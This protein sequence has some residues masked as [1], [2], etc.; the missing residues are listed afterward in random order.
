MY[1]DKAKSFLNLG[2]T[3][4]LVSVDSFFQIKERFDVWGT[5]KCFTSKK[6]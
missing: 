3:M 1:Q 6:R 2:M 5:I 4:P